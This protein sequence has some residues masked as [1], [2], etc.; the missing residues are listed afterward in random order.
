MF[1]CQGYRYKYTA[2][3]ADI[4]RRVN[5]EKN[6]LCQNYLTDTILHSGV[7][8]NLHFYSSYLDFQFTENVSNKSW[9]S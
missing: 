9:K 4:Q 5:I 7:G 3:I 8:P 1:I 2:D 6:A